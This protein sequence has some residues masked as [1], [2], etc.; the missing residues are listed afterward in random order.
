MSADTDQ[1]EA[2]TTCWIDNEWNELENKFPLG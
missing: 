2:I 1:V